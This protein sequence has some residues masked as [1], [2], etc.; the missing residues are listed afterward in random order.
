MSSFRS[1]GVLLLAGVVTG[2]LSGGCSAIVNP[3]PTRLGGTDAPTLDGGG[4]DV[5]PVPDGGVRD[6]GT[7]APAPA[8]V[9][10]SDCDDGIECTNDACRTG[11]C[12]FT[13]DDTECGDGERCSAAAG[14]VPIRCAS[15][16]ECSDANAC[17]G[18]ETCN[19][20][21]PGADPRTGCVDGSPPMCNDGLTCTT[22]SCDPTAGCVAVPNDALCDDGVDCTTDV[23]SG[24]A[25]PTGCEFIPDDTVCD[26][27]C[28]VGGTCGAG[29]CVG[30]TPRNCSDGTDCTADSCDA[31]AGGVC[32]NTPVDADMD[33]AAVAR[34]AS[35]MACA[36][37]TDC[38]DS[39]E[40]VRP[41]ATELCN[42]F[43]DNCNGMTDEGCATDGDDCAGA[44]AI[45]LTGMPLSGRVD[46]TFSSFAP[47]Y[48]ACAGV[49]RDAVYYIDLTTA[50]DVRID[51]MGSAVADTVL[52]VSLGT[53]TG[54]SFAAACN[55]DQDPS[56]VIT[57]RIWLH[58]I[59]PRTPGGSLRVY[60]LVKAY[61]GDAGG[62]FRVNV[63]AAPARSDACTEPLDLSGGGLVVGAINPAILG[64]QRGSCDADIVDTDSEAI[65]RITGPGDN[66][67]WSIEA[68]SSSFTPVLYTRGSGASTCTMSGS[69]TS[70]DVGD[71]AGL[72]R[73]T[74][75]PATNGRSTFFFLDGAPS[76]STGAAPY[77]LS[78]DP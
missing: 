5:G 57:S 52:G 36:G 22:D 2:S 29:G 11:A 27:G 56:S 46:A 51:T 66:Q 42:G 31:S 34:T 55:D 74:N 3:D 33:G 21:G 67:L 26:G 4:V 50:S 69:E 65:F 32:V 64:G 7:D 71:A 39:N 73:V 20:D 13:P 63:Q 75:V 76:V 78:Y 41:G 45:P 10:D 6:G 35:G 72:A 58:N 12:V 44:T 23:C 70:C 60:I 15:D 59:G 48:P 49:G 1:L 24:T 14:C 53:C 25:G 47:D 62:A 16:A 77:T 8:C 37:G 40:A 54:P 28:T 30:G 18:D 19:P 61:A 43:D 68:R 17:N 9:R 38:D